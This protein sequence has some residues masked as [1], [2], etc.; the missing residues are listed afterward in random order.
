MGLYCVTNEEN[1]YFERVGNLV[2]ENSQVITLN[3]GNDKV[4]FE[5]NEVTK[6][7]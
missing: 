6:I 5:K 3:L 2:N 7:L 4:S 1:L